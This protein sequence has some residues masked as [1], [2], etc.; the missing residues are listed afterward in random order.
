MQGFAGQLQ[1]RFTDR[2]RKG[3]M[4]V[5]VL[6]HVLCGGL[7]VCYQHRFGDQAN[8]TGPYQVYTD[9][10]AVFYRYQLREP[11]VLFVYR[12]PGYHLEGETDCL[13]IEAGLPGFGFGVAYL[14]H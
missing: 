5:K 12:G 11:D 6:R 4:W 10:G 1:R 3:W 2:L 13:D 9:Y 7:P 8:D 14:G